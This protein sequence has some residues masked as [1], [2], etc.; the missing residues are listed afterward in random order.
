[1]TKRIGM[2]R[3][4]GLS[5]SSRRRARP[6]LCLCNR[7]VGS[8]ITGLPGPSTVASAFAKFIRDVRFGS[9]K[10]LVSARSADAADN[11]CDFRRRLACPEGD[12]SFFPFPDVLVAAGRTVLLPC[13]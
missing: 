6:L 1:M 2:K 9:R 12:L 5:T 13:D 4:C 11:A 10:T 3:I 7:S 8:Y